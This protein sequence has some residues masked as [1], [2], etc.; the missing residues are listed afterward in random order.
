MDGL[1][2][3]KKIRAINPSVGVVMATSIEDEKIAGEAAQLGSYYCVLKPFEL[4]YLKLVVTARLL[5]AS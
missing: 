5:T 1:L 2:T 3:L 4:A